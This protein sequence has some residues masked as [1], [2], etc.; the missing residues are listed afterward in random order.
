VTAGPANIT[1]PNDPNQCGAIVNYP[2]TNGGCGSITFNPP[3][4]SFFPIGTTTVTATANAG[5][6]TFTVTVTDTQA[7]TITCPA[8]VTATTGG[9]NN[10]SVVVTYPPPSASDNCPGVTAQC[11]PPSGSSFLVGTTTVTCTATDAAGNTASCSFTVTVFNTAITSTL[12][13]DSLRWNS[14]TGDYVFT[15]PGSHGFTLSGRGTASVVNGVRTLT[16]FKADRRISAMFLLGQQ[17]GR[18]TITVLVAQGV[19]QTFV[20]TSP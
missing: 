2:A 6:A 1:V 9:P 11:T 16:D 8:N 10:P 20:I 4:G 17:T 18:A 12:T 19:W 7:P 13:G 5:S 15:H 3:S 14:G